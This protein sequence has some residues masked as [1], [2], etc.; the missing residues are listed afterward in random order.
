MKYGDHNTLN[1]ALEV[2]E[3]L[4]LSAT[5]EFWLFLTTPLSPPII[6]QNIWSLDTF[7]TLSL[8]EKSDTESQL[9]APCDSYFEISEEVDTSTTQ[10]QPT[11]TKPPSAQVQ[12]SG[13]V[14][15]SSSLDSWSVASAQ[16]EV[17][18]LTGTSNVPLQDLVEYTYQHI[19]SHSRVSV[20]S[21]GLSVVAAA[22]TLYPKCLTEL[23]DLESFLDSEDPKLVSRMSNLLAQLIATEVRLNGGRFDLCRPIVGVACRKIADILG[24]ESPVVLKAACESLRVCLLPLL[25]SSHPNKAI[26][27][28]EKLI[29][30]T[31]INYWLLKVELLQT[32][33]V[34]DYAQLA[35]VKPSLLLKILEG[36]AIPL[37]SDSDYR[38]RS[39]V[40]ATLTQLAKSLDYTPNH[41]LS[42][43]RQHAKLSYGHL[44]IST[45]QLS[46]AGIGRTDVKTVPTVPSCLEHI[47]W[48]C[49]V[50]LGA[51]ANH[52][53][54][55]GAL[56]ALCALTEEYPPPTLPSMWGVNGSDC[57][58][59]EMI[60]Q[61]L[62]GEL[63]G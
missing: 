12:L 48:Q 56:E 8:D 32:L 44:H 16:T 34:V 46:L 22:V 41:L 35:V 31:D 47:V 60:L 26:E 58:L 45:M 33:A 62:R 28:L 7:D 49:T 21:V 61:L 1:I 9:D 52:W 23:T 59:L 24:S 55:R 43:G 18:Y 50:F 29:T 17:G 2:L 36:V 19:L 25:G 53:G 38:V 14:S 54:Q 51:S 13:R 63:D 30:L 42:L 5:P 15:P 27:L 39:A 20:K 6:A 4:F 57:G 10:A 40:S 37:L 11:T 3:N